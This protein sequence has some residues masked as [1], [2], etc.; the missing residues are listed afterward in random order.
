MS[1]KER[2][3]RRLC[4]K[5]LQTYFDNSQKYARQRKDF[6]SS[7][8]AHKKLSVDEICDGVC[9]FTIFANAPERQ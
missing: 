5:A 3:A 6:V 4:E 9:L 8:D 2:E 1:L 7:G